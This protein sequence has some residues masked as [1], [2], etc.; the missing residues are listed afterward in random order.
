MSPTPSSAVRQAARLSLQ[1]LRE[2]LVD[3]IHGL[4][5]RLA[6]GHE[7][8]PEAS[9]GGSENAASST[10]DDGC[11]AML[12]HAQSELDEVQAALLRLDNDSWGRCTACGEAIDEPRLQALPAAALCL[13]CRQDLEHY[14]TQ[15]P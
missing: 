13:P 4:R 12:D 10:R 8:A 11:L 3:E 5:E 6:A 7:E 1:S 14:G 2:Q 15:R 9:F